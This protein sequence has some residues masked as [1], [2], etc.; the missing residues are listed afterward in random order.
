MYAPSLG[1]QLP[2]S[3][4]NLSST[5]S[6][7]SETLKTDMTSLCHAGQL[8][9]CSMVVCGSGWGWN[10]ALKA[11]TDWKLALPL[12]LDR[13]TGFVQVEALFPARLSCN[14]A[15]GPSLLD[16]ERA[17]HSHTVCSP[18]QTGAYAES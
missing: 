6:E 1:S 7:L 3:L 15:C 12:Q 2:S 5:T 13:T 14:P 4:G 11:T 17:T 10:S 9:L 16:L 18:H 8:G